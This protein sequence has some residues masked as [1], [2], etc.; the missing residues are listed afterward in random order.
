MV[1][2]AMTPIG[3]K[4]IERAL[5]GRCPICNGYFGTGDDDFKTVSHPT[6]SM[7]LWIHKRHYVAD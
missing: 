3:D 4:V 5:A 2:I 7:K 1:V 6:L